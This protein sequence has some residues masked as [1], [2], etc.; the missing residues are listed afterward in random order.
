MTNILMLNVFQQFEFPVGPFAEDGCAEWFH[1]FLDGDR[2]ACELIL[3]GTIGD[4]D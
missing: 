2:R 4:V 3:G 1:D